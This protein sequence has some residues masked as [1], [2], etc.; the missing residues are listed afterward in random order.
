MLTVVKFSTK[1]RY[2]A[3][4]PSLEETIKEIQ[5]VMK[6]I[7]KITY[8]EEKGRPKIIYIKWKPFFN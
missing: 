6:I 4:D 5:K 8:F 7:V 1:A 2:Q 3:K